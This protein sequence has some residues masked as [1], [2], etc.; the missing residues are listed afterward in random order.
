MTS[1]VLWSRSRAFVT[2]L[3]ALCVLLFSQA[4]F[5]AGRIEW[6]SKD[7]Q[8]REGGSWR[9]EVAIYLPRAPDVAHVPM[10]FEFQPE[11]YYERAMMDGD[12]LVERVVPL[13]NRQALIESVDVGFLDAGSGKTESRTRFTFK[14]TRAHGYEAG[15]YKV[16]IRDGRNGQVIGTPQVLKF[17]GENEII[18]RRAMVFSGEKK[19]KKKDD[20]EGGEKK[21]DSGDEKKAEEKKADEPSEKPAA[22]EE[23]S[24]KEDS[25]SNGAEDETIKKKPGGCGCRLEASGAE[26]HGTFA[27]A[28][29]TGAVVVA[30]RRRRAA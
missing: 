1:L 25:G 2:S 22:A 23:P 18:D 24:E 12:K 21:A 4:A 26:N 19:K 15:E 6:K 16:T 13:E 29:L 5:A 20:A 27:L 28:L 11:A 7:L 17:K 8:E 14:V 3:M 9:L 10:K 30:R